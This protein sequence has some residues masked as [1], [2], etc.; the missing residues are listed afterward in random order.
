MGET[1]LIMV[2]FFPTFILE[3]NEGSITFEE[4]WSHSQN[5]Q[6]GNIS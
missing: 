5:C 2:F 1:R 6:A 3:K 4:D